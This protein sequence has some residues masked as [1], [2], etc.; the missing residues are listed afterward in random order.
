MIRSSFSALLGLSLLGS[1]LLLEAPAFAAE[2]AIGYVN[3]Q[4]AIVEVEDGKKAKATL[5]E[6][7]KK[8]QV[9]LRAKEEELEKMKERLQSSGLNQDDPAARAQM[10]DF[11][12]KFLALRETLMKEQQEL[13]KLEVEALSKITAKLRKIIEA[14]GKKEGY[15]LIME[16]QESSLLFAKPHLDLTNEVIRKYNAKPSK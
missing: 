5:E 2:G 15:L 6:T 11:Q 9:A 16:A 4:R 14:I 10:L 1:L 8:K 3:L 12:K 13:K 7:F